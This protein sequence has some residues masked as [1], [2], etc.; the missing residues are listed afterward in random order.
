MK[1]KNIKF[2]F[3]NLKNIKIYIDETLIREAFENILYNLCENSHE[4]SLIEL[5]VSVSAYRVI[6]TFL[7]RNINFCKENFERQNLSSNGY[8]KLGY[9]SGL[10]MAKKIISAHLGSVKTG[11]Q[12]NEYSVIKITLPKAM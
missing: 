10:N 9:N 2:R 5:S 6:F 12:N 11:R 3:Q 4:K 1:S 7:C 8:Q